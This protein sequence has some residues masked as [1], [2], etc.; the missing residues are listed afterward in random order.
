MCEVYKGCLRMLLLGSRDKHLM[1][2]D[3]VAGF[4]VAAR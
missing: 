4:V 3:E 1:S 2:M